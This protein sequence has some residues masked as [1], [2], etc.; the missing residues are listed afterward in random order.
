MQCYGSSGWREIEGCLRIVLM[1]RRSQ[2]LL[3]A[4]AS[5]GKAFV[6]VS[7]QELFRSWSS[8]S[9]GCVH[10]VLA[11]SSSY[12]HTPGGMLKLNLIGVFPR[13]WVRVVREW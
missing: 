2:I 5:R 3:F 11:H 1:Q 12:I 10:S 6:D 13:I 9:K 8:F 4:W 7:V